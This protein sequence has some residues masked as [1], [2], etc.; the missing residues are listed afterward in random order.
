MGDGSGLTGLNAAQL[1]GTMPDAQ[2]SSNVALLSAD[3]TF[4]GQNT[5]SNSV[6][7]G[8]VTLDA[9]GAA[10]AFN[11]KYT[12]GIRSSFGL[13]AVSG[14]YSTHAL[15]GDTVLRAAAGKLLLQVGNGASAIAI[16]TNNFI[17]IG[18]TR[19]EERRVGKEC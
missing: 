13:A 6:V 5:F 17:G 8:G 10:G 14:N 4:T 9:S 18:K 11:L 7:G 19:S 12:N 15:A 3:Q 1:G 2:L 16:S